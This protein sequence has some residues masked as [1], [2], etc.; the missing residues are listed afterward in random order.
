LDLLLELEDEVDVRI[1]LDN[2]FGLASY[3]EHRFSDKEQRD[4]HPLRL[5]STL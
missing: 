1:A 5:I 3:W 4:K 2:K